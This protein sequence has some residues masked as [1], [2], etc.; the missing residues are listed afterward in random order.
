MLFYSLTLNLPSP[1]FSPFC[2]CVLV[3]IVSNVRRVGSSTEF[4]IVRSFS[5]RFVSALVIFNESF[6]DVLPDVD[7]VVSLDKCH[8][9]VKSMSTPASNG[10]RKANEDESISKRLQSNIFGQQRPQKS[11]NRKRLSFLLLSL[12]RSKLQFRGKMFTHTHTHTL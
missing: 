11:R 8:S 5:N 2:C 1:S 3:S 6:V 4:S 9:T 7:L 10:F 12:V